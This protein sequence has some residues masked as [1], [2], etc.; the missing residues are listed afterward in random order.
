MTKGANASLTLF[1]IS[2]GGSVHFICCVFDSSCISSGSLYKCKYTVNVCETKLHVDNFCCRGKR[3]V[4]KGF[5][6]Y[7]G[8]GNIL[9]A[10]VSC[11]RC[12]KEGNLHT[13]VSTL[14]STCQQAPKSNE[15]RLRYS[16]QV[17]ST[18]CRHQTVFSGRK[19][20]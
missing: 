14:T 16:S 15:K 10:T 11:K 13:Y 18:A 3:D 1:V 19:I 4:F 17:V 6:I 12:Y 20:I 5:L 9:T 8:S 7:Q 2:A